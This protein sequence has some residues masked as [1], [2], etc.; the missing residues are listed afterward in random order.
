M[1]KKTPRAPAAPWKVASFSSLMLIVVCGGSTYFFFRMFGLSMGLQPFVPTLQWFQTQVW[2]NATSVDGTLFL[3]LPLAAMFVFAIVI[4][5]LVLVHVLRRYRKYL[6]SGHDFKELLS[7]IKD[8][9]DLR[10]R[11]RIDKIRNQPEL[12]KFL[13]RMREAVEKRSV[14]FEEKEKDFE[15]SL[16]LAEKTKEEQALLRMTRECET[17]YEAIRRAP[18]F[19]MNLDISTIGLKRVEGAI[20]DALGRVGTATDRGALERAVT[21]LEKTN[22]AM[23]AEIVSLAGELREGAHAAKEIERLVAR[24]SGNGHGITSVDPSVFERRVRSVVE[25][26]ESLERLSVTLEELGEEARGVAINTALQAGSGDGTQAD[27]IQLA[28]DVKDVATRFNEMSRS[29]INLTQGLKGSMT[30]LGAEVNQLVGAI[31]DSTDAG[32]PDEVRGSV[33]GK[34]SHWGERLML[35]A[36]RVEGARSTHHEAARPAPEEPE[37]EVSHTAF[38]TPEQE[39]S[40]TTFKMPETTTAATATDTVATETAGTVGEPRAGD[41]ELSGP[42]F[43]DTDESQH[44]EATV[45]DE[46]GTQVGEEELFVDLGGESASATGEVDELL[47]DESLSGGTVDAPLKNMTGGTVAGETIE[48]HKPPT[49]ADTTSRGPE[50]EVFTEGFELETHRHSNKQTGSTADAV[51]SSGKDDAVFD[52]YEL[53]AVDYDPAVHG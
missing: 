3:M 4:S 23:R 12:R 8:I 11:Q 5:H 48:D 26:C 50:R 1:S 39:F 21:T 46:F 43:P 45:D 52:L 13:L 38:R 41:F 9:K 33:A 27:L 37:Q 16:R 35:M 49:V 51:G 44:T 40:A 10:D 6:D 17:L 42:E 30:T 36:E 34:I 14:E 18:D 7:T 22:S 32:G 29:Y 24:H 47:R 15:I 20:R 53:G 28:E 31:H 25:V 2:E 19:P